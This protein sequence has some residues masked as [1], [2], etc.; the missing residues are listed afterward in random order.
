MQNKI[1]RLFLGMVMFLTVCAGCEGTEQMQDLADDVLD[2]ELIFL[3]DDMMGDVVVVYTEYA[4]EEEYPELAAFLAEYYDITEEEQK[5]TRYYYNYYD[6]NE[7]E[8]DEIITVVISDELTDSSGD[9]VLILSEEN[10]TFVVIEAFERAHTP[11]M[12][13]ESMTNGWHDIVLDV[14]GKGVEEG[15]L[16]CHYSAEGGYQEGETE[17]LDDMPQDCTITQLLSNNLIDDMD[18]GDYMTIAPR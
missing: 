9:P 6:L 8:T 15:Y 18:R 16:L 3:T 7:D 5:E 1:K 4:E 14:Y 12:A 13:R 17:L 2:T 11:I 10:D